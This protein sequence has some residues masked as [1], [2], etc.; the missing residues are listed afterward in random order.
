LRRATMP[1]DTSM[2]NMDSSMHKMDSSHK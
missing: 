2:H 1:A